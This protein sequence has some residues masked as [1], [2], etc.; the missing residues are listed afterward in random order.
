MK[1]VYI[2]AYLAGNL[3]DDLMVRILC[4]R[5]P[6]TRFYVYANE[7]Y[8]E[9]YKDIQNLKVYSP[10]DR[11]SKILDG[12]MR[13]VKKTNDGMWKTMVRLADATVYIGGSIFVHHFDDFRNVH[14]DLELKRRSKRVYVVGANFGPYTDESFYEA[15]KE[16]FAR[17]DHVCF[18]DTYSKG[19]FADY[20]NVR[21]APDVVFNY[22]LEK[23]VQQRKQVLF[24]VISLDERVGKFALC[25]YSEPYYRTMAKMADIF[26]EKGYMIKF[27][28]FCQFQND[29][30]AIKKIIDRM[31][32]EY[33]KSVS[34]IY[35]DTNYKE[36]VE[37]FAESEIIVGTRF[38][39]VILGW[40]TEKK[41]LPVVYDQKIMHT[42]EDNDFKM[43]VKM[44]DLEEM[45][46]QDIED[47]IDKV[48][49]STPFAAGDL[50]KEAEKQFSD[51]DDFLKS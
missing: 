4:E 47:R 34:E 3:G 25:Q 6:E 27:V 30:G 39:S 13:K 43:Y 22:K 44:S 48:I 28:S 15:Y 5:Y 12:L 37:S 51:L 24:S 2:Y 38:H 40:L 41:V 49:D 16:V 33:K 8:K 23:K 7:S 26:V 1:R 9:R 35:Y 10:S 50:V 45:T 20:S 11:I 21:Y 18:R 46:D 36:I 17:Y 19:L 32:E 31:S 14:G 29:E 42:L